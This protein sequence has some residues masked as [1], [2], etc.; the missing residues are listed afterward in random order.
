MSTLR[1]L[2]LAAILL[3]AVIC[4]AAN[5]CPTGAI[6]PHPTIISSF[7]ADSSCLDSAKR[8]NPGSG[9]GPDHPEC[10]VACESSYTTYCTA[11][12]NLHTYAWTV[13]GGTIIGSSTNNCVTVHWGAM[14]SGQITVVETDTNGCVGTDDRCVKIIESPIAAFSAPL[15][16]CKNTAVNFTNQSVNAISY[17]WNF[18][19]G[20]TSTLQNPSHTYTTGGT[21]TVT[22]VAYN[23]C[24]C[25]D[26][27]SHVI[28]ISN[29]SGPQIGCPATVCAHATACYSSNSGC[30]GGVYHW[31]ATGGTITG[32]STG[33]GLTNICVLW[34]AGPIGTVS[35]YITGCGTVCNDTTTV[36]VPIISSNGPITGPTTVCM[37]SNSVYTLPLWPGTYYNWTTSC[38]TIIAG[39]NSNS[40]QVHWPSFPMTC[41]IIAT[42][43]NILLG[44]GGTDTVVV[45][46]KPEFMIFGTA[47]PFCVGDVTNFSANDNANWVVSGGTVISGN[48]TSSVQIQWT[49]GGIHTIVATTL[50]PANWC[51]AT[52]TFV[53]SVIAVPPPLAITGPQ[54]VCPGTAYSYTVT[55]SGPGYT[56]YWTA[57]GGSII[58]SNTGPTVTVQWSGAGTLSV[59]QVLTTA[60]F[61]KSAPISI[62]IGIVSIA[63]IT[64]P[65][66]VCMDQTVT[67]SAGPPNPNIVY[68]WT[69]EDG[70]SNPSSAGSITGGQ[71]TNSITVLWHGPGGSA[72]VHLSV[73]SI[74]LTLP[75]TITPKPS[76]VITMTGHVC[77]PGGGVTLG[78][79]QTYTSYSWS[80]GFTTPTINVS[81]SG[82]YCVTVT[83][84]SGCAAQAC[85]TV[86]HTPP[87]IASISTPDQITY[88]TPPTPTINVTL[89]ALQGPNYKY[90]WTPGGATTP[91]ITVT[92]TG[93]YYCVVTDSVTGCSATSN[94]ITISAGPCTGGGTCTPQAYT[95]DFT[96]SNVAGQCNN[97]QFTQSSTN[98]T[99]FSWSF[100]DGGNGTGSTPTH[101]YAQAGYYSVQLCGNVPSTTTGTCPVCTTKTVLIPIAADFTYVTVCGVVTFTDIS[102]FVPSSPITS[103]NWSFPGGTP[104]S[105]NSQ[106]PG[107]VT[108]TIP[109]TYAVTLTISNGSCTSTITR[110]VVIAPPPSSAFTLP[111]TACAG[112]TVSM[113]SPSAFTYAWNFGD[114]ATSA[115]GT[116]SHA[117]TTPGPYTVS[118]TV[119]D[120]NGC[121]S[122]TTHS[123]TILAPPVGCSI[124][125]TNPPPFC[126]GDSVLL[127]AS[128]GI[129][130][131][132]Q[133]G[134]VP[135]P[136]ATAQT[137]YASLPGNYTVIVTGA[138]GCTCTT[139]AVVVTVNPSPPATITANGNAT[140]CGLGN[141]L[142]L[143]APTGAGY[144]YM[145]STGDTTQ[146]ITVIFNS[147]GLFTFIVTVKDSTGC[148]ATS[149]PFAVHVFNTPPPPVITPSGPTIFCKGGSVMLTSSYPTNNLWSTG[150]TTQ[151]ITVSTGGVYSV[152]HTAPN[153]CSSTS[154]ITVTLAP[155]PDFSLFPF[156]CDLLCDT[157]KIP[158]PI[159]PYPGYYTYQWLFN[160]NPISPANGVNDTLTPVGS[161]LY[162]L[163]LTGPGPTFCTDTSNVYNLSLKNC[164][165]NCHSTICGRKWNDLNGN[166]KFNYG[167]E[168]GI[169]HWKICLVKCNVDHYPTKDT[170]ACTYTDSSGFYCF[171]NLC[172]GDYCIVEEHRPGWAQTWP[173]N[174][175]FYHVHVGDSTTLMGL[176]FGNKFKCL[177]IW[178]TLDTVGISPVQVL[179]PDVVLPQCE[180]Y[181]VRISYQQDLAAPFVPV[182]EGFIAPNVNPFPDSCR[183]GWY[184]IVR[185]HLGNYKFDR[186]Y[187]NDT[188]RSDQGDSVVVQLTDENAGSTV[189]ILN[190]PAPDTTVK[191]RTFTAGQL[192]QLDQATPV[193]RPGRGKPVKM[194]NTA[195]V[196][197][198][199]LRQGGKLIAGLQDRQVAGKIRAYVYPLKQGDVFKT[200]YTKGFTH[201]GPPRGLDFDVNHKIILKRQKS[202]PANKHDNVFVANLLALKI[203]ILAS[204]YGKTPPGFGELVYLPATGSSS[205]WFTAGQEYTVSMIAD[206][207][208]SMLT[209]WDGVS[210]QEYQDINAILDSLNSSFS[211]PL[212]FDGD[213]TLSWM[214]GSKLHLAGARALSDVPTL[215]Q[216]SGI[217]P[218]TIPD[219]PVPTTPDAFSLEQ[220]YPNPFN[221]STQIRFT[222][223]QQAYVTLTIYN[224]LGQ[225]VATLADHQLM[226]EGT[227]EVEFDAGRLSSGVYFYHLTAQSIGDVDGEPPQTYHA[228]RK[229]VLMK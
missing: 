95:L 225:R 14:G 185:K 52:A 8:G 202:V 220:N 212:P 206:L 54:T 75:I 2:F 94:T 91:T 3:C 156:G 143:S 226:E 128:T 76:P 18:G 65:S 167:T 168:Y 6:P 110:N 148:Q 215:V 186:I 166:H 165:S 9:T 180:P 20:G 47:G 69:I 27:V 109:G 200:F 218:R 22:L 151:S 183:H 214:V 162:S 135:I 228:M 132:W 129:A 205:P 40:I 191:F 13:T 21:Y 219:R 17:F 99:G 49:S 138:N 153:G 71:G 140:I 174:P 50:N 108:Y 102:T 173:I 145:W 130:W 70:L 161:G 25:S 111:S 106:N 97:I 98:V 178:V 223:P 159:G 58:G 92:S 229:M 158:G 59:Q 217:V 164:D 171:H 61:C 179:S 207:A 188:L 16:A 62:P 33:V 45:T 154:S 43:H 181:P 31:S 192:A 1:Y 213:D 163:I 89:Y 139:P 147:P 182:F 66:T 204:E 175:P 203:N 170:I 189:L 34:G 157:V 114:G 93:S 209:K 149:A 146:Q 11:F 131:L 136:G 87:P 35:L 10:L 48:G 190:V 74:N 121:T 176:D 122:T 216:E 41:T 64:G 112:T 51:N 39:Q 134:G 24:G 117:W 120:V 115:L 73:C 72:V 201:N 124:A 101:V 23:K 105:S 194:P 83:N 210:Y 84:A 196:I 32:P 100:G 86:P 137:Y 38:G 169:P 79:T 125:P 172:A 12:H 211:K 208:D 88:C 55:P 85:I 28:N 5:T 116:T 68:T 30:P 150:A 7:L 37:G 119:T 80:N 63:S 227:D 113:T 4:T 15:N 44:C 57:T 103:W 46:I 195:N 118:L 222:L 90:L 144:S 133:L 36:S 78:L 26:S 19:D 126:A 56:Y 60:P 155:D 127:T 224:V 77:D 67:Y 81:A 142:T 29:L 141:S 53:V 193:K 177:Q 82:Q 187:V 199:M 197:D 221:P 104:G 152:T 184:S 123:I 42:W 96:T 107:T 198:E 160:G